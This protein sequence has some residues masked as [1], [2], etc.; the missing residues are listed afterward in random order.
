MVSLGPTP[1]GL[2]QAVL[3]PGARRVAEPRGDLGEV[4]DGVEPLGH[5]DAV[6]GGLDRAWQQVAVVGDDP[7]GDRLR[8]VVGVGQQRLVEAAGAE[9]EMRKR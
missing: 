3:Q 1:V 6:A 7:E 5:A 2:R 4:D 8:Q 9:V